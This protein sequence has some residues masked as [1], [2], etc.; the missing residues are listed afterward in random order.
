MFILP[1]I[2]NNS[3]TVRLKIAPGAQ[4]RCGSILSI[5]LCLL[6]S[7]QTISAQKK[8]KKKP[9]VSKEQS[10][11]LAEDELSRYRIVIPS[12]ATV[13]ELKASTVLQDYVLQI[14]SA[15][16]PILTSD[17][18]RSSYEIVLGQNERLDE[19]NIGIN[20]NT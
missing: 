9:K 13:H 16:I 7:V 4:F 5:I 15:V 19:L 12:F 20:L 2:N 1:S 11:V 17:K 8:S 10:I 14:S 18:H 6:V 3:M